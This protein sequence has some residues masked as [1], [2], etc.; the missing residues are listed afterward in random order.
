M[1]RN[2]NGILNVCGAVVLGGGAIFLLT[3]IRTTERLLDKYDSIDG[4]VLA[5]VER[6]QDAYLEERLKQLHANDSW[7][8][9][10]VNAGG[11][12]SPRQDVLFWEH[13]A[14][15][16]PRSTDA[17]GVR[18]GR[19][20]LFADQSRRW[21]VS[22]LSLDSKSDWSVADVPLI[23]EEVASFSVTVNA[24]TGVIVS[25]PTVMVNDCWQL[26]GLPAVEPIVLA[27][28]RDAGVTQTPSAK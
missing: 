8:Q 5:S 21:T 27:T 17:F 26:A 2:G 1:V 11:D 16:E 18:R 19:P 15:K 3:R 24:H 25:S 14:I 10:V 4:L 13:V 6:I 23:P 9:A 28:L 22:V 7:M 12:L 20:F